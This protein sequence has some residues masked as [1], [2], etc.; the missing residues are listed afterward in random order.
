MVEWEAAIYSRQNGT[1]CPFCSNSKVLEGFN[2]LE[3]R[4][5][6]IAKEWHPTKNG[7][8]LP[9]NIIASSDKL[10]WWLG[11]CNHE[12][13]AKVRL[14]LYG[15]KCPIC[16]ENAGKKIARRRILI[17]GVNDL[18]IE[19]PQLAKE[20]HPTK[21]GD[22]L[23]SNFLTGSKKRVWWLCQNGH[24]WEAVINKRNKGNNCPKCQ[25]K[26]RRKS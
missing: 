14:R 3:T 24:E 19:N 2:D 15:S 12:W 5:P 22:L 21:N 1:S 18:E 26:K 16:Y 6:E 11:E 23:P 9:T 13:E 4:N 20:W 7:Q 10:V 25:R 8:L 17:K